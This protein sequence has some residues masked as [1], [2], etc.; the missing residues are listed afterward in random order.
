MK[1]KVIFL[2][3][4]FL[5][6]QQLVS[7]EQ[8]YPD[9]FP[10]Q[11]IRL[12][13]GIFKHA[14]DLNIQSLLEYDTDRLLAPFFKTAGL[15]T[16][17]SSFPSWITLDG[18][19]LGHYLSAL[20][21]HYAATGSTDCKNR[22]DYVVSELKRCQ[23]AIGNGYIGGVDLAFW[24]NVKAGNIHAEPFGLN[25]VWSPWYNIHKAFAGLRDAW[26]YGRNEDAKEM[27]LY[28]CDWG[29][30]IIDP[31]S[32]SQM[33]TMMICEYGGMNEVYADAYAISGDIKYLNAAKRFSHKVFFDKLSARIDNLDNMHANT[34]IPKAIGYARVAELD[35]EATAYT[36]A[37][38]FF[39]ETVT[40][41]RS[42][43]S[44]AN[45][46]DEHFP[47][48]SACREY[49]ET[50][51]GPESCNTYNM[52]RLTGNLFSMNPDAKYADFYERAM[53]NHTLST[54]HPG[55]GGYVYYT[56][57]RPRHYRIY[58]EPNVSMW[59]CVG[60]GMENHGKY[61]EFIYTHSGDSLYLNLFIASELNW[62]E[63][64]ITIEQET[65]FPDADSSK[66]IIKTDTPREFTLKVRYPGWVKP[67]EMSVVCNGVNYA[68]SA[69][70][71][72]YVTITR[73]W[74]NNDAVEI[75]TPMHV[76]IEELPNVP[77][78]IAVM[79]GPVLL[80][81]RTGTEHLAG[82]IADEK[83]WINYADGPLFPLTEAPIIVGEREE[84]LEKLNN[85]QAVPGK[86]LQFTAP[87]LFILEKD[88]DLVFEPFF[89][90][91]DSRYM[92]YWLSMTE[93]EYLKV[94]DEMERTEY[95]KITLDERTVDVVA[96]AEQQP[97]LD[98]QLQSHASNLGYHM[99]EGWRDAGSGGFFSYR[100]RTDEK[101]ELFL[102]VRYWGNESGS[103]TFDILIDGKVLVTEN[104][105]GKWNKNEFVNVE[106]PIPANMLT[107]KSFIT[108]RFQPKA[109]N[110]AGGVFNLRLLTKKKIDTFE[111]SLLIRNIESKLQKINI[112]SGVGE[113]P[114]KIVGEFETTLNASKALMEDEEATE[115]DISNEVASLKEAYRNFLAEKTG[116]PLIHFQAAENNQI[117]DLTG[118]NFN[119]ELKNM[120]N[121]REMG[122]Y[123]VINLG[124]ANGY[125]DMSAEAGDAL[126]QMEDFS[127]SVYYHIRSGVSIVGRGNFLW[128]FSTREN[129]SE[130]TGGYIAYRVNAQRYALSEKGWG[131]ESEALQIGLP[132]TKGKWQHL[133][134]TQTDNIAQIYING[135]LKAEGKMY[136]TPS[137]IG[138]TSYNWLGKSPF[139]TDAYL[140]GTLL[141]DFKVMDRTLKLSEIEELAGEVSR[142]QYAYDNPA[143]TSN[144]SGNSTMA[145]AENNKIIIHR[146][147]SIE[148]CQVYNVL[149]VSLFSVDLTD[150]I[151]EIKTQPG[152]Y[153]VKTSTGLTQKLI[154]N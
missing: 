65:L 150:E 13:E 128:T 61:G 57:A 69:S 12:K 89:R 62:R 68:A 48:A 75:K 37:A 5:V 34:Q 70:P 131:N 108:V 97:E 2:S 58:S 144:P 6:S 43:A 41:N 29:L 83:R 109:N 93:K 80:G 103:R 153:I 60:T 31:L 1:F 154:V 104:I 107:G 67:G 40:S 86:T 129:C 125:V 3:L 9:H 140:R 27:F 25:G 95:E 130:D 42:L 53:M 94:R 92:M 112:G 115:E 11:D 117:I 116:P 21:I 22:M 8:L 119:A 123:Q 55:H 85:M 87:D 114:E 74:S 78:Y 16:D 101:E 64:G 133:V 24:N 99:E 7:Q 106:Y 132:A 14:M 124:N 49:I 138:A 134:Y 71:A 147:Q 18:H 28:L 73:T 90:I 139:P 72:S 111:L 45:S 23:T 63:K 20:A 149:G 50:R 126:A 81:A 51:N 59:C 135:E 33:E 148:T 79:Y 35:N 122:T 66:L 100:L 44:G 82:L 15:H 10:L 47:P 26:A 4:L 46:R 137:E 91:H 19:V 38:K 96:P 127:V 32:E 136:C 105:V 88:K 84:I 76:S 143:G 118:N 56:S 30:T 17:A 152:I 146:T 120:A 121:T 142:L 151:T 54:Q 141:Y 102:M 39:W 145:W 110:V 113:Y 52:L 36:T 77:E 98:H